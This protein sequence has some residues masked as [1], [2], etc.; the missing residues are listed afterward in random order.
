MPLKSIH[1]KQI[2]PKTDLEKTPVRVQQRT[3]TVGKRPPAGLPG[4]EPWSVGYW[5][6]PQSILAPHGAAAGGGGTVRGEN[7]A[8][9]PR[10]AG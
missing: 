6:R 1:Q 10:L 3:D 7:M 2:S 5:Q 8:R 9:S 4:L